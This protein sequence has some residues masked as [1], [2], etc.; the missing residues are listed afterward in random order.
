MGSAAA[1][2][3]AAAA[4]AAAVA[5]AVGVVDAAVPLELMGVGPLHASTSL[6]RATPSMARVGGWVSGWC[7]Q[8][9]LMHVGHLSAGRCTAP[10][11]SA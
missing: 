2:V 10:F 8:W 6:R 11:S 4:A 1:A 7:W 3:A 9:L 5:L